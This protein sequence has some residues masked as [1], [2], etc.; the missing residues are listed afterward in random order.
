LW[1][2]E[3][4]AMFKHTLRSLFVTCLLT[5]TAV[6]TT[7]D[8]FVG[9]WKLNTFKS[10]LID[11]MKVRNLGDSTYEFDFGG[12]PE[13]IVLDGTFQPGVFRTM[14]S[15]INEG[16]GGWKVMRKKDGR[17]LLT[18][19]WRL[20]QDG[21]TLNDKYTEFAPNGSATT[22]NYVYK[23]TA[24]GSGFT[25]TWESRFPLSSADVLKIRPYEGNGL[26][27]VRSSEGTRNLKFDGKDYPVAA[28]GVADGFT[29]SARRVDDQTLEISVK[30]NGKIARTERVE[31]SRD[32]RTLTRTVRPVGQ[33]EP[34]IF[35]FER[36]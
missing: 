25:G 5:A 24:A 32:L 11:Q 16:P 17:M 10:K 34:D 7:V 23:R 12:V 2:Q 27:L 30:L 8:T 36:Q 21:N 18:A 19:T 9:D 4:N 26:S 15:V 31:L 33:R 3:V 1:L 13:R 28:R 22:T 35:V 20:S 6:G 29:R 14:L